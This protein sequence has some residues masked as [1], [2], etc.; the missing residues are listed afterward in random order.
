MRVL[1]FFAIVATVFSANVSIKNQRADEIIEEDA[2]QH[3][4]RSGKEIFEH[5]V[6]L[7]KE[8]KKERS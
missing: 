8:L 3:T 1:F 6:G 4:R 7:A 2:S 5:L